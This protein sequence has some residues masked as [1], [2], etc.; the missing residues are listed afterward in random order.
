VTDLTLYAI[1]EDLQS[2]LDSVEVC[3]EELRPELEAR[4]AEYVGSEIAK[5]DG[6]GRVLSSLDAV[7]SHARAE[8]ERLRARQKSAEN[9]AERLK[10]YILHV[11]AQ[12]D[13]KPLKGNYVTFFASRSEAVIIDDPETVPA[14]WKRT[15]VSV[16]IP[17]EPVKRAIKAGQT[18][19][20]AHIEQREYL[21]RR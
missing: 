6:V 3:P 20:G 8:I 7:Q 21:G 13:G 15:T 18:I 4:I 17:K 19:P 12:R 2:L 14:E 11:L 1:E 9:N 16:D 5:V 10:A